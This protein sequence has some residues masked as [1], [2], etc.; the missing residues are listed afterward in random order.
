MAMV[1]RT[2]RLDEQRYLGGPVTA[3]WSLFQD[4]RLQLA[5]VTAGALCGQRLFHQCAFEI[6]IAYLDD[7]VFDNQ[8]ADGSKGRLRHQ[9]GMH[10][11][12]W[13]SVGAS[14]RLGH[15]EQPPEQASALRFGSDE[16]E[17]NIA[18]AFDTHEAKDAIPRAANGN[19][20]I[21]K[22]RFALR[23][24]PA[25]RDPS[26]ALCLRIFARPVADG[27]ENDVRKFGVVG[28]GCPG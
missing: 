21:G 17:V 12:P 22:P 8:K 10:P 11:K 6:L 1:G 14:A 15:V 27:V 25:H 24:T 9:A 16:G 4:K 2:F 20:L 23:P 7:L 13:F 26:H 28:G 18:A 19:I 3:G 5:G